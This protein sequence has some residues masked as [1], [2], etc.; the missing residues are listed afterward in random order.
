MELPGKDEMQIRVE[1]DRSKIEFK[2]DS[3][4]LNE[5][6]CPVKTGGLTHL[7]PHKY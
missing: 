7:A 5:A 3:R 4:K 6:K 2:S 1:R